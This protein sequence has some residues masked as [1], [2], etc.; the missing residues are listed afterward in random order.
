MG[1][2]GFIGC[3]V[4]DN[5]GALGGVSWCCQLDI[6]GVHGT[7]RSILM[8]DDFRIPSS[9]TGIVCAP[10]LHILLRPHFAGVFVGSCVLS[11][12]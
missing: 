6:P 5:C 3:T 7:G 12:L 10:A 2:P 8:V 11:Q 1:H 4:V 9:T